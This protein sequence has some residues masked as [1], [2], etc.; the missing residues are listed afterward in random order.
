[1]IVFHP[2]RQSFADLCTKWDRHVRHDFETAAPGLAGRLRWLARAAA[3][4]AS[5]CS[6]RAASV[7]PPRRNRPRAPAG[8]SVLV[9]I[10]LYRA[11]RMLSALS[12]GTGVDASRQWNRS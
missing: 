10:R 6:R 12:D 4:A 8:G 7:L 3:V 11:G 5:P 2:A 9:R 1:M